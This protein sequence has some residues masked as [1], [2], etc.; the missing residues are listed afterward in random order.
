[1]L[2]RIKKIALF[3]ALSGIL[4]GFVAEQVAMFHDADLTSINESSDSEKKD[5]SESKKLGKG[6]EFGPKTMPFMASD[7]LLDGASRNLLNTDLIIL[8]SGSYISILTPP[9]ER[10]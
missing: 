9:P 7:F 6:D 2:K 5:S 1:M 4:T 3:F 8:Y 10:V